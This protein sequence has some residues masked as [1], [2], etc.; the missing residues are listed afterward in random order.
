[1]TLT[2]AA[3]DDVH[4]ALVPE[5]MAAGPAHR[6][7][8]AGDDDHGRLVG[9]SLALALLREIAD[10]AYLMDRDGRVTFI[11]A[12]GLRHLGRRAPADRLVGRYLWDLWPDAAAEALRQAVSEAAE[13]E[14]VSLPAIAC[15]RDQAPAVTCVV[16]LCPVE[17]SA[18]RLAKILVLARAG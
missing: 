5:P 4:M 6:M 18:G 1:M 2:A 14:T 17:D 16:S 12:A 3:K 11:N 7:S 9:A 15:P 10:A 8:R 13:G